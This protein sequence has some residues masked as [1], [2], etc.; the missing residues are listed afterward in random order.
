MRFV[1]SIDPGGVH[2]G[3]AFW[4]ARNDRNRY[5]EQLWECHW[6]VEMTPA[7]CVDFAHDRVHSP[8]PPEAILCEGFWLRGGI[9]AIRQT[10]S[11]METTEVIGAIRHDVRRCNERHGTNVGFITVANGQQAIITRLNAAQYSWTAHGQG[12]HAK[13]AEA[14]GVRGL[15]L[16]VRQ[17]KQYDDR[18]KREDVERH[19]K[20]EAE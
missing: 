19:K 4:Q 12:T 11:Q 5:D 14:V 8:D 10:G 7:E 9:D 17:L 20:V 6:A 1:I 18:K 16:K 3:V 15:G 2:C 13:D